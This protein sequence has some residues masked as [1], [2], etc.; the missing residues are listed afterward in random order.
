MHSK[1]AHKLKVLSLFLFCASHLIRTTSC[2]VPSD[3]RHHLAASSSRHLTVLYVE[4]KKRKRNEMTIAEL[5]EKAQRNPSILQ[6]QPD[7][8]KNKRKR[9]RKRV[10]APKQKYL[11]AS[12]R[13][14]L[15][16][17]GKLISDESETNKQDEFNPL[18]QARQLGMVNAAAQ[19]ADA[20]VDTVEPE[21]MGQIR[22]GDE[23]G[24]SGSLAYII[25]K[26]VGWSILGSGGKKRAST[27]KEKVNDDS[28]FMASADNHAEHNSIKI[29]EEE[30]EDGS[31]D[32]L[33][34]D[35]RDMLALLT[36][37][38]REEYEKEMGAYADDASSIDETINSDK[39]RGA[40]VRR[41][42]VQ[43][44]D[45]STDTLEYDET[46]ILACM[47]PE[48]IEEFMA[49]GGFG[50]DTTTIRLFRKLYER[51]KPDQQ[52][53]AKRHPLHLQLGHP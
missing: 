23:A 9:T 51:L 49:E 6:Q 45:G 47:T 2:F 43:E 22:V 37:E 30:E 8:K 32:L 35:E 1:G 34:Y 53:E 3:A 10:D 7:A 33:E 26:P 24:S 5:I 50:D 42:K 46:D 48:E 52:E 41:V 13:Q 21:I 44:E 12:Q 27:T 18:V 17:Q 29:Q 16:R 4:K 28:V 19:H 40:R 20:L 38:E 11:Y 39:K 31:N 15:E 25:Y 36:P 14:A